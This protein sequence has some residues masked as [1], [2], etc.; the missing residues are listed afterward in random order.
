MGINRKLK[1]KITMKLIWFLSILI[2]TCAKAQESN[3]TWKVDLTVLDD[4]GLPFPDAGVSIQYSIPTQIGEQERD[5]EVTGVTD[6]NGKFFGSHVDTGSI[7]INL[8]IGKAGYYPVGVVYELAGKHS[9]EKWDLH[10]TWT[11]KKIINPIPMYAKNLR[12]LMPV[13]DKPAGF[14]FLA[15]DWVTPYGKGTNTDILFT[16]HK[17]NPKLKYYDYMLTV[18]FP[19]SGDGIQEFRVPHTRFPRQGSAL[20]S[21]QQAPAAGYQPQW[22]LPKVSQRDEERNYYFRVRTVLDERGNVKSALYGKIYG[23]FMQFRY[24]LNPT[25]NDRNV[26]FDPKQNLFKSFKPLERVV[27]P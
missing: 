27:E 17:E 5:A 7:S 23:D 6:A 3:D 11:L 16:G 14:D 25:P 21:S 13:F 9:P 1:M 15:G 24:F 4:N 20:R 18:S 22:V 12:L 26:E 10:P 2:V 19:N 8:H